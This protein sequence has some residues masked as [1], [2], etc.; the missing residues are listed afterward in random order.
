MVCQFDMVIIYKDFNKPVTHINSIPTT[1][2]DS[3]KDWLNEM[4][5][6]YFEGPLNL[7]WPMIMKTVTKDPHDFFFT[8]GGWSF[9]DMESDGS[10]DEESEES[11]SSRPR[12]RTPRTRKAL[13]TPRPAA[14][15]P[16]APRALAPMKTSP[17]MIGMS[18][19][20]RQ[21]DKIS[22]SRNPRLTKQERENVKC[23]ILEKKKPKK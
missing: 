13:T 5:L 11:P 12:T 21:N 9:L 15:F 19:M 17:V 6:P 4:D 23:I 10:G 8:Q 7:N 3:V 2:L 14:T 1:Q 18:L 16:R 22:V 20:P